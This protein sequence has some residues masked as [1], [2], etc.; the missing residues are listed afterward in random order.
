[1]LIADSSYRISLSRGNE[2]LP[3]V[4]PT[5]VAT[6]DDI[7]LKYMCTQGG[8]FVSMFYSILPIIDDTME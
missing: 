3:V 7:V 8:L 5:W 2:G 6:V 1:M 4:Q